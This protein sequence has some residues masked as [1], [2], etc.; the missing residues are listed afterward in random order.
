QTGQACVGENRLQ[1]FRQPPLSLGPGRT[2]LFA[3]TED[4]GPASA[5]RCEQSALLQVPVGAGDRVE[6]DTQITGQLPDRRQGIARAKLPAGDGSPQ[7]D[8]DL[9]G[10]RYVGVEADSEHEPFVSHN[11]TMSIPRRVRIPALMIGKGSVRPAHTLRM[12]CSA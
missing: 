12:K 9:L 5:C 7:A 4:L 6:V 8:G 3:V 2:G 11:D 10:E 1:A